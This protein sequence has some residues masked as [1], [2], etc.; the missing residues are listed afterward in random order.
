V[1]TTNELVDLGGSLA[2]R[3]KNGH[4]HPFSRDKLFASVLRA[5]GHRKDAVGAAG[6][7]TATVIAKLRAHTNAAS[8]QPQDI[9]AM[10]Y[11]TLAHFDTA[12][13][14]QYQAYHPEHV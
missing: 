14:V 6:A 10:T 5:C 3:S 1:F 11:E 4:L 12:A 9:A 2:V 13:S 8:V 7:L